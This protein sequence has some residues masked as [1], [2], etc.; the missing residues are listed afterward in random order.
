M[1]ISLRLE[2]KNEKLHLQKCLR[3][4][5]AIRLVRDNTSGCRGAR[6]MTE[7]FSTLDVLRKPVPSRPAVALGRLLPQELFHRERDWRVDTHGVTVCQ[8]AVGEPSAQEGSNLTWLVVTPQSIEAV[9]TAWFSILLFVVML[10]LSTTYVARCSRSFRKAFVHWK[11]S[12]TIIGVS[13]GMEPHIDGT[14]YCMS[15]LSLM[16]RQA[17]TE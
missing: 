7:W 4:V 17:C 12:S 9:T 8:C 1:C 14:S 2:K 3:R 10:Y 11:A 16:R 5:E 13:A 15:S 6:L